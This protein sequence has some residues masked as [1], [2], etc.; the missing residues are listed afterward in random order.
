MPNGGPV[1]RRATIGFRNLKT[2]ERF[3]AE[4]SA[5]GTF[6]LHKSLGEPASYQVSVFDAGNL[7][8]RAITGTG[9]TIAGRSVQFPR[10]GVVQ[11]KVTLTKG[12]ARIDGTV[13]EQ[14]KPVSE[15]MVL[16]VPGSP[17]KDEDSFRRDQSDSDGTFSLMQVM[18]GRY[19]LV[20]IQ[21]GW[22]LN[23]RDPAVLKPYLKHGQA[24]EI[25]ALQTYKASVKVQTYV[26]DSAKSSPP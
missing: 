1:P 16:L 11:L 5:K 17:E 9:A 19:T 23:W 14:D 24:I 2:G 15:A 8:V 12:L 26:A 7:G 22:D 4:I 20:A 3:G 13:L 25:V 10:T 21:N 18:P 6:Q